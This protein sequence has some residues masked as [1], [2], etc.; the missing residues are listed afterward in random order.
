MADFNDIFKDFHIT[1]ERMADKGVLLVTGKEGNPMTIGWGQLGV[2]WGK[3]VFTVMVRPSRYS[4]ELINNIVEFS[5]NVMPEGYGKIL[6]ICGSKSGRDT[7]KLTLCGLNLHEGDS[8]DIPGLSGA[9]VV[10]ECRTIH[11]NDLV[12]ASLPAELRMRYYPQDDF[13]SFYFGEV[14]NVRR[15]S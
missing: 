4:Y 6:G 5:V 8:I 15:K 2:V 13:H 7:D 14:M 3:P 1:A 11:T 12:P 10:Y 9:E